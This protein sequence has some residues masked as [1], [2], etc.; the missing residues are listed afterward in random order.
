MILFFFSIPTFC[1]CDCYDFRFFAPNNNV[2]YNPIVCL[3]PFH[4]V[5]T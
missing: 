1:S 4:K 3:K 5:I 2:K